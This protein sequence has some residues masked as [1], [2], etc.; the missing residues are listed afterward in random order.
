[1]HLEELDL[2]YNQLN[3]GIPQDLT[4]L[5]NLCTLN[6]AHNQL[7]GP[8]PTQNHFNTRF[9]NVSY[10]NNPGLC[11]YPLSSSCNT[12]I[13]DARSYL[14]MTS[15]STGGPKQQRLLIVIWYHEFVSPWALLVGYPAGLALGIFLR[16][17]L[18]SKLK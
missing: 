18:S 7:E 16:H 17:L 14:G 2:S 1:M 4:S 15:T 8:I 6:L 12:S 9:T 11:G 3:G 13:D 10:E 5:D